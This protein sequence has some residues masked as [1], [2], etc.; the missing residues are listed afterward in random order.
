MLLNY[1]NDLEEMGVSSFGIDLRK[2][3]A[4]LALSVAKAFSARD[5]SLTEDIKSMCGGVLNTGHYQRGV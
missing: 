5:Q 2:R 3:P 4:E 1:A